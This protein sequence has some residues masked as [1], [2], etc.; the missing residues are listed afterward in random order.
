VLF[1]LYLQSGGSNVARMIGR[2]TTVIALSRILVAVD[3]SGPGQAAFRQALALSHARNAEL[4]VV[5]AVP[6]NERFSSGARARIVMI[7]AL[8]RAAEASGVKLRVSVQQGDPAGVILLHANARPFDLIVIGTNQRTGYGRFRIGSVAEHVTQRATSPVLIVPESDVEINDDGTRRFQSSFRSIVAPI[9]F[10]EGAG[11]ALEQALRIATDGGSRVT[12]VHV[13]QA[14]TT[15]ASGYG[16]PLSVPEYGHLMQ[17][18][19]WQRLQDLVP[20]GARATRNVRARVVTGTPADEI[21]RVA[22]ETNADLI[23]MGVTPRGAL[24]RKIFGSTAARVIR[25]ANRPVLAI[26]D[27][28]E[29]HAAVP[30]SSASTIAAAA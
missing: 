20:E 2:S 29:R 21:V 8:R 28:A 14:G 16:S 11:A 7:G 1:L 3:F 12:L 24:G 13:L 6:A 4:T 30:D 17:R 22:E 23:V 9:D 15:G 5:H 18:D 19:A 27:H 26:P 25:T 10:T